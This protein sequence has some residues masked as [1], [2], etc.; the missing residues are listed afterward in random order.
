MV[1]IL[2]ISLIEAAL[3]SSSTG[4]AWSPAAK[5]PLQ[6]NSAFGIAGQQCVNSTVYIYCIG[7]QDVNGGPRSEV[8]DALVQSGTSRNITS[9]TPDPHSYP[10]A[11]NGQACVAYSDYAY[12][13]GGSY[14]DGG[15]DV[16][17]SYFTPLSGNGTTGSWTST[18]AYP[19]PVDSE[20]CAASIG[21]IYCVGGNNET[22]GTNADS[23]LSNSVWYATLSPSGI[24]AWSRTT[25][26]PAN[27]YLPS[28]FAYDGYIYCLGGTDINNNAESGDY[29]A[30]L[31][32]SGVG[33]WVATTSYPIQVS[34][35][36]CGFSSGYVDCVGGQENSNSYTNAV[37]YAQVSSNS[38]G[39]WKQSGNY[40]RSV[41][42]TCVVSSGY[43]YCVGGFDSSSLGENGAT[44]FAPLSA[45]DSASGSD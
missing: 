27:I 6:L 41:G 16:A 29:S 38:I 36:A 11:I 10:V 33:E 24:G 3:E 13:V 7:G 1:A 17:S 20:Y 44:Y 35:Q 30:S 21:H 18:T 32:P 12:C 4:P 40:P 14:D 15:D 39:T 34:G 25:P 8:Y 9:W 2:A 42:T 22:D 31:T 45:I 26:Y 5:Y 19:I 23:T 37:Y 43:M 28:C